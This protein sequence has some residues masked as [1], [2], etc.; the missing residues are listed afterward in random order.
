MPPPSPPCSDTTGSFAPCASRPS[1]S[2]TS[3]RN[4]F[5]KWRP[6]TLKTNRHVESCTLKVAGAE[7]TGASRH[8]HHPE[9]MEITQPRVARNEPPW[10]G[11][12]NV[13]YP[14]RV[15]S[16]RKDARVSTAEMPPD[17]PATPLFPSTCN[18]QLATCN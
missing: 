2:T 7:S 4:S 13:F 14:E 6:N 18:L 10:D 17:K 12:S 11:W 16:E 3:R 1:N 8:C 15:A 5:P 9:R